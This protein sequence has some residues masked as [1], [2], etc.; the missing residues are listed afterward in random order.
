MMN[1]TK[2]SSLTGIIPHRAPTDTHLDS[3]H[4]PLEGTLHRAAILRQGILHTKA[5]ILP[6]ATPRLAIHPIKAILQQVILVNITQVMYLDFLYLFAC[7]L[8][9][10]L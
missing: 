4:P 3:T 10:G 6:L 2:G 1:L 7:D 8:L 5:A 9:K